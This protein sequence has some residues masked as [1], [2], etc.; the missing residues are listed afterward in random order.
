[1]KAYRTN[2]EHFPNTQE[3]AP[4][5]GDGRTWSAA[6]EYLNKHHNSG[7]SDL[8]YEVDGRMRGEDVTEED[9]KRTIADA[10]RAGIH[11][12]FK[13]KGKCSLGIRWDTLAAICIRKLGKSLVY[14][15]DGIWDPPPPKPP[16]CEMTREEFDSEVDRLRRQLKRE[17]Q[18]KDWK[19]AVRAQKLTRNYP[20][21]PCQYFKQSGGPP[22]SWRE[23]LG[24]QR[25]PSL[26]K[27]RHVRDAKGINTRQ[28]WDRAHEAGDLS[29]DFFSSEYLRRAD[30][31]FFTDA[32]PAGADHH[33]AHSTKLIKQIHADIRAGKG[34]ME[35]ARTRKV[36]RTTVT[37]I[38][39][40]RHYSCN[41]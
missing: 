28:A 16:K 12:T 27:H 19:E 6:N 10:F 22:L 41:L 20:W 37:E 21:N 1:M 13:T 29:V 33:G 4:I 38:R 31:G 7:L 15:R 35:I 23:L 26:A 3:R 24:H 9:V 14:Y 32:S 34:T 39:M 11:P 40:G 17:P 5:E 18:H 30:P 25:R 8:G 2:H 36:N